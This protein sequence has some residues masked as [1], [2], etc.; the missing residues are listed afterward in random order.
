M[1]KNPFSGLTKHEWLLWSIS[2]IIVTLS[3]LL[4]SSLEPVTFAATVI[5]VTSLIFVARGDV[6]GQILGVIFSIL[7]AINSYKF[8][9]FG[10]MIT[11]LGMTMPIAVISIITWLRNPFEKGRNEV[12]IHR[13]S[14]RELL[15]M[16]ILAISVTVMFYFI[17]K[18]LGTA[19]LLV[20]TISITTSF[21]ASYLM[22][23]RNSYYAV[24]YAAND[25]VLIILWISASLKN[26]SYS[27][28]IVCFLMFLV[29]DLYGF[30]SWKR[31]EK[32]Q[33]MKIFDE[34]L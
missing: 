22:M 21:L 1:L 13:L 27:P 26:P 14:R 24:A 11:Y 16:M 9:Y 15:L 32:K 30:V 8:R 20:S 12:K 28:M 29:N 18:M 25:I 4:T 5:G 6:W 10:E 7:Y 31:R 3:N 19:N 33:S 34:V 17:L 23:Y 2:L